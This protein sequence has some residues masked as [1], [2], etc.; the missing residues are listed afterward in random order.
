MVQ[1]NKKFKYLRIMLNSMKYLNIGYYWVVF[2]NA[3]FPQKRIFWKWLNLETFLWTE[4]SRRIKK[5]LFNPIRA[6]NC[7]FFEIENIIY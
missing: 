6:F 1:R 5:N 7:P 4:G 3:N 2:L